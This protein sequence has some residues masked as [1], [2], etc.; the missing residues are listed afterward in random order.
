M[1]TKL[2]GTWVGSSGLAAM[3]VSYSRVESSLSHQLAMPRSEKYWRRLLWLPLLVFLLQ[4]CGG[5]PP[6]EP[7]GEPRARYESSR[8]RALAWLYSVDVDATSL[9]QHR[10]KGKKKLAEALGGYVLFRRHADE[11]E[12]RI[13][14]ER[15]RE[16]MAMPGNRGSLYHDLGKDRTDDT[17]FKQNSM[18][19]LRVLWLLQQLGHETSDYL[20]EVRSVKPRLDAHLQKRG[21]W[22]RAMFREYYQRFGLEWPSELPVGADNDI[23]PEVRGQLS[24]SAYERD[25]AY[26]LTHEVFV[27]F[28]YGDAPTQ[29]RLSAEDLCYLSRILGPLVHRFLVERNDVDLGAE[30]LLCMSYLGL[31]SSRAYIDGAQRSSAHSTR[32]PALCSLDAQARVT[33]RSQ[34]S[35]G[36]LRPRHLT[37]PG[38]STATNIPREEPCTPRCWQRT[39]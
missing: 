22:Q 12:R 25:R 34:E 23:G 7:M 31:T 20:G 11:T 3:A 27:A 37:G 5:T 2:E 6:G 13:I 24:V 29:S 35:N 36:C 18:S 8:R 15:V 14:D 39:H 10:I 1:G 33:C 9:L 4:P 16:L 19:Y 28:D 21:P 32:A 26:A 38:V 30:L 17:T